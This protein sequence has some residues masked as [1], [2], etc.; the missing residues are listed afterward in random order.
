MDYG[1]SVD[2]EVGVVVCGD[3]FGSG[4]VVSA[5]VPEAFPFVFDF[6]DC[7]FLLV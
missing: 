3:A 1:A 7:L 2:E 4:F 5:F 6:V